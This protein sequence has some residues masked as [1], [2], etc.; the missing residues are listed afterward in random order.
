MSY[1]RGW[2]YALDRA[3]EEI[4]IYLGVD[5]STNEVIERIKGLKV[6]EN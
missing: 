1:I 2:N 5:K 6:Y 3:I 4:K